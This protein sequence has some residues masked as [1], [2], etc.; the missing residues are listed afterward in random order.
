MFFSLFKPPIP[1]KRNKQML[2]FALHVAVFDVDC[3]QF[4]FLEDASALFFFKKLCAPCKTNHILP[5]L[6]S[7]DRFPM[8]RSPSSVEARRKGCI[9]QPRDL[10]GWAKVRDGRE[11]KSFHSPKGHWPT[12]G[13]LT[14]FKQNSFAPFHGAN[15]L[16]ARALLQIWLHRHHLRCRVLHR[17]GNFRVLLAMGFCKGFA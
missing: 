3:L 7:M 8:L 5:P 2:L 11:G 4:G 12:I 9:L 1:P 15:I 10:E 6:R 17:T 16:F 14:Y 13:P